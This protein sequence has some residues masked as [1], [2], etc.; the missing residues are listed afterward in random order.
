VSL[1]TKYSPVNRQYGYTMHGNHRVP[2]LLTLNRWFANPSLSTFQLLSCAFQGKLPCC[3][4][5]GAF[6]SYDATAPKIPEIHPKF[7]LIY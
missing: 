6:K 1:C 5:I 3:H 2:S 7:F 4:R